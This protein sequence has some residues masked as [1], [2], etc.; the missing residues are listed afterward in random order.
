VVAGRLSRARERVATAGRPAVPAVPSWA[1][2]RLRAAWPAARR[3]WPGV[4]GPGGGGQDQGAGGALR[5]GYLHPAVLRGPQPTD[6]VGEL[7]ELREQR[8]DSG[9]VAGDGAGHAGGRQQ[10]GGDPQPLPG[11]ADRRQLTEPFPAGPVVV[12]R[13]LGQRAAAVAL[14]QPPGRGQPVRGGPGGV[15][16]GGWVTGATASRVRSAAS[17]A[18]LVARCHIA[19]RPAPPSNVDAAGGWLVGSQRACS[20][21]SDPLP[22]EVGRSAGR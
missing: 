8:R 17:A 16:R 12:Q 18:A 7:S 1:A 2:P 22:P 9:G 20:L 19:A 5:R 11:R 10:P 21:G 13:G 14:Q 3:W 15:R 6:G 4:G